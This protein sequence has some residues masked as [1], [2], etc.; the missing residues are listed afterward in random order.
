MIAAPRQVLLIWVQSALQAARCGRRP[1][2]HPSE[3]RASLVDLERLAAEL[4]SL[5]L[6]AE[7]G[8]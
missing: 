6:A 3:N 2:V 4:K 7:E 8:S 5:A 1:A